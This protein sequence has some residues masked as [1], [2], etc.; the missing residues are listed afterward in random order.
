MAGVPYDLLDEDDLPDEKAF[1]HR[2]VT[3]SPGGVLI[4][5]SYGWWTGC[6]EATDQY[7]AENK[8]QILLNRID[9]AGR[10]GIKPWI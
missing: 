5:D 8:T 1:S 3:Q 9:E 7:L 4:I 2:G 6:R 10:I